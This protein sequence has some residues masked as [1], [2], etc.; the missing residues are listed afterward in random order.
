VN[1]DKDA[2]EKRE[3]SPATNKDKTNF[4]QKVFQA[5]G[6]AGGTVGD[7]VGQ[8]GGAVGNAAGQVVQTVG[9]VAGQTAQVVGNVADNTGGKVSLL[10]AD[11]NKPDAGSGRSLAELAQA[12]A[13]WVRQKNKGRVQIEP[14]ASDRPE[15]LLKLQEENIPLPQK[16]LFV[17]APLAQQSLTSRLL[18]QEFKKQKFA[19]VAVLAQEWPMTRTSLEDDLSVFIWKDG[20]R[21]GKDGTAADYLT[22]WLVDDGAVGYQFEKKKLIDNS[23]KSQALLPEET[24]FIGREELVSLVG[25]SIADFNET[26]RG[27]SWIFSVWGEGGVGKSYFLQHIEQLFGP[28]ILFARLDHENLEDSEEGLVHFIRELAAKLKQQGCPMPK[29]DRKNGELLRLAGGNNPVAN[30]AGVVQNVGSVLG[31]QQV[32]K[33]AKELTKATRWAGFVSKLSGWM[34]VGGTAADFGYSLYERITETQKARNEAILKHDALKELD[35]LHN[36]NP[37]HI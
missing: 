22:R 24:F 33:V 23:A 29:F 18:S 11:K 28:R 7:L 19:G 35:N 21:L 4:A 36:K 12:F 17:F 25:R 9:N 2:K 15:L 37:Y 26:N 34:S 31:D 13:S 5:V 6:Q 32:H 10:F 3:N 27:L 8:A 20:I 14:L 30:V 1:N 16:Y